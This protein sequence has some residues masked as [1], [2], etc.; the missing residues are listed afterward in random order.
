MQ[1]MLLW[2]YEARRAGWPAP[3][4]PVAMASLAIAGAVLAERSGTPD[5][6]VSRL[7]L[8]GLE[9][10]IPLA[11]GMATVTAG[12]VDRCRE[13]QLASPMSYAATLGRRLAV[14]VAASAAVAVLYSAVLKVTGWWSGPEL[15][16]GLMVWAAPLVWFTGLGSLVA[17]L[18]RSVVFATS[19]LGAVWVTEQGFGHLMYG[20]DW[21]RP[22]FLFMTTRVG[23]E[24][25]WTV[26]RAALLGSGA[27]MLAAAFLVTLLRSAQSLTDDEA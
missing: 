19:A 27:L 6:N 16:A 21:T 22:L 7:L 9:A 3:A 8:T 13:L 14:V 4:G 1:P 25:G 10:L 24:D 2:R 17:V 15:P 11:A 23:T 12:A 18:G 26:N 20:N 5:Q